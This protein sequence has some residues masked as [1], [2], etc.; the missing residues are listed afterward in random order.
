MKKNHVLLFAKPVF[1]QNSRS[2]L[3]AVFQLK[4]DADF[5]GLFRDDERFTLISLSFRAV[6]FTPLGLP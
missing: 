6:G 1:D 4:N 2:L 5:R 3:D